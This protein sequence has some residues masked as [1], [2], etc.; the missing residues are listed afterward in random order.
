[1]TQEQLSEESGI[2]MR[3]L[4]RR[5]HKT[6]PSITNLEELDAIARVLGLSIADLISDAPALAAEAVAR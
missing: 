1:M 4:S 6:N 2:P 5:L 3:T